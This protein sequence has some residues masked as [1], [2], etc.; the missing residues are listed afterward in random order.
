MDLPTPL[1]RAIERKRLQN[2]PLLLE[3][4]ANPD[5]VP[6]DVQILFSRMERRFTS[7]PNQHPAALCNPITA[8]QVCSVHMQTA[9]LSECELEERRGNGKCSP[10][11]TEPHHYGIDHSSDEAMPHSVVRAGAST[12]EILDALLEY[13]AD[14]T[15]WRK[16]RNSTVDELQEEAELSPSALAI[17]TPL[18]SAVAH[19]NMTMLLTLLERGFDPNARELAA[20]SQAI[21]PAQ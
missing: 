15:F 9:P 11:W 6:V 1:L 17:S 21:T 2:V 3:A 18:R 14:A 8:D 5:G 16:P 12:A 10:F 13:G 4:G 20:G 7:R 19:D